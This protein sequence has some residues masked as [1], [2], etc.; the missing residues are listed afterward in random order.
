MTQNVSSA[1]E[2]IESV[3]K[4]SAI[5]KKLAAEIL[6]AIPDVIEDG[7]KID[8]EVRV[9]GLGTFRL[10]WTRGK[11]GRNPKTGERV[12]IPAHNRVVFLPE[13]AFKEYINRDNRLL[14]YK[15]I[16]SAEQAVEQE[17]IEQD[18]YQ[19]QPMPETE[20]GTIIQAGGL[21]T[22][23]LFHYQPHLQPESEPIRVSES[24]T[25]P[26]IGPSPRKRRIH[27]IVPVA[28]G[29]II[30]LS[31]VFYLR[32]FQASRQSAVGS[33]QSAVGSRQSAVVSQQ[34]ADSIQREVEPTQNSQLKTPNSAL[35]TQNPEL[36]PVP[37][38]NH[39]FQLA[40]EI[41]GNPYLWVLIYKENHEKIPDPDIVVS[42]NELL[43]PALEGEADH[44]SRNDSMAVSEGYRLVYEYYKDRDEIRAKDCSRAMK[45][46]RP[47][48]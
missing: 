8:G 14:N 28:V 34:S 42:G 41:Y 10:R 21:E 2:I 39:L 18:Q 46:Y 43:I 47:K 27:W 20:P 40:R 16:P 15:I 45:R 24:E 19:Y 26:Q 30:I 38:G 5:T 7:L 31:G 1:R 37:E 22:E 3:A 23:P 11:M 9:K 33:R 17:I 13:Q 35:S 32:N 29:V 25:E 44:L 4:Q 48:S 6:H 12:E 36:K